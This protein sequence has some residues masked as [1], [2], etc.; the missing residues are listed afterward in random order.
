M[1]LWLRISSE[2][3]DRGEERRERYSE[4]ERRGG[5]EGESSE[6]G[7]GQLTA[8]PSDVRLVCSPCHRETGRETSR[9][10]WEKR[11][12]RGREGKDERKGDDGWRREDNRREAELELK[13]RRRGT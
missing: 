11:E 6:G 5:G 7:R 3:D 1:D 12:K 8:R 4:L 2:N 10:E 13:E 9:E